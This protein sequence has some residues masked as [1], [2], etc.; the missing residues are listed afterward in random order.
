MWS[1]VFTTADEILID[2]V[3]LT[4]D[5]GFRWRPKGF[6]LSHLKQGMKRLGFQTLAFDRFIDVPVPTDLTYELPKDF[7]NMKN[8][9]LYDGEDCNVSR[10]ANV[11]WKRNYF[12]RGQGYLAN[13]D[14]SNTWDPFHAP[15]NQYW[16]WGQDP[17][18]YYYNVQNGLLM[19]S[20]NCTNF[21]RMH[22]EFHTLGVSGEEIMVPEFM[23]EALKYFICYTVCVNRFKEDKSLWGPLMGE[24]KVNWK[25]S[26]D[27]AKAL[28]ST[29]DQK[30]REDLYETLAKFGR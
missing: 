10:R 30:A 27:E 5:E 4:G 6:Y 25:T 17:W 26:E 21:Q 23:R 28:I 15:V 9:W 13:N 12:T 7:W 19:L 14:W 16:F 8:F 24:M 1:N 2:V 22:I 3:Q 20:S 11:Y 18:L 29:L